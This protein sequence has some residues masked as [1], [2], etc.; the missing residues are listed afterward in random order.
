MLERLAHAKINLYLR[1]RGKRP[2]GFHELETL[3][4][5]IDLAD[6]LI[7]QPESGPFQLEIKNAQLGPVSENLVVRA[8]N[9]FRET[10]G[11]K[12]AGRVT[13]HKQ[14]PAGAGLGGGSSNAAAMLMLLN[15]YYGS[16][17]LL[18]DLE[19]LALQLGSDVPFFLHGGTQLGKGRGE[20]LSKAE[21][22]KDLPRSGFLLMPGLHIGSGDVFRGL[23]GRFGG[24]GKASIGENDLLKS[25]KAVNPE[26]GAIYN[27]LAEVLT[28][29]LFF[30]TGSGSTMVLL[31][32]ASHLPE[33]VMALSMQKG[34]EIVPFR[35]FQG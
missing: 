14:I 5:E 13:L 12:V 33:S 2:D 34:V 27:Q 8:A 10:V 29:A 18:A 35:F 4:Q 1:V 20:R 25:A 22:S 21:L 16:P 28:D 24:E 26:F 3:F 17:L 23:Q 30:M 19:S 11:C 32:Q 7:W 9:L 6:T 31:T 15:A